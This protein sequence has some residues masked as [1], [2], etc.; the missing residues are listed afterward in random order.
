MVNTGWGVIDGQVLGVL[1]TVS[2]GEGEE[3]IGQ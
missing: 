1:S 2:R 3:L